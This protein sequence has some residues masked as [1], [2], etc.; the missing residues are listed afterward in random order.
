VSDERKQ[1]LDAIRKYSDILTELARA[2]DRLRW[3]AEQEGHTDAFLALAEAAGSLTLDGMR[4][5]ATVLGILM[6]SE[7]VGGVE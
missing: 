7:K 5:T 1:R 2:Y 6:R 4:Q 3:M